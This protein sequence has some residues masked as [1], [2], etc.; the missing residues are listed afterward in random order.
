MVAL[1]VARQDHTTLEA[2]FTAVAADVVRLRQTLSL[3]EQVQTDLAL[4]YI[5]RGQAATENL[6]LRSA[7]EELQAVVAEKEETVMNLR[8]A[9]SSQV[10]PI[11]TPA[12]LLTWPGIA[13]AARVHLE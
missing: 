9:V 6:K 3:G 11:T 12:G 2:E 5:L 10:L 7:L 1:A 13:G 4:C 8:A